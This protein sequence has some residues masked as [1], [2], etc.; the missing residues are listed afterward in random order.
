MSETDLFGNDLAPRQKRTDSSPRITGRKGQ[1]PE[2]GQWLSC[3]ICGTR[4][5]RRQSYVDRGIVLTC[6]KSACKSAAMK[7]EGNPFWGKRHDETARQRMRSNHKAPAPGKKTGPPKGYRHTPEA[8]EKMR[9]A[10]LD[11]WRDNRDEMIARLPRG[12]A[13]HYHKLPEERRYRKEF[14]PLQRR[15][16]TDD[17]CCWCGSTENLTLDHIIPIF[18]GGEPVRSNAQTLCH[19]CNLWK[20][21]F[22]DRPRYFAGQAA[23][24]ADINPE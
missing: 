22:V 1:R 5:Y 24:G 6:G 15:E 2:T 13:H 14:T 8:R 3:S 17:K 20:V 11:R 16:W 19:P 18:D 4:F 12:E 7:G 21:W 23:K 9:Q 10:M